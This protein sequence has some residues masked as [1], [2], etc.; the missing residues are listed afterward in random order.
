MFRG[1]VWKL[2]GIGLLG[3]LVGARGLVAVVFMVLSSVHG[4]PLRE[5][6]DLSG[7]GCP[8]G[9]VEDLS[10]GKCVI[11]TQS[12]ATISYVLHVWLASRISKP[13][14]DERF[15]SEPLRKSKAT[16]KK[17]LPCFTLLHFLVILRASS[18]S[19]G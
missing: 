4:T 10:K 11:S 6:I 7:I 8:S 3:A 13:I 1:H 2:L 12:K 14:K 17:S 16:R 5:S 19:V 15:L 9:M 18:L